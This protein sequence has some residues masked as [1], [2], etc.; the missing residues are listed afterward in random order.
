MPGIPGQVPSLVSSR[1][2]SGLFVWVVRR[3]IHQHRKNSYYEILGV[4]PNDNQGDIKKAFYRLSMELHPDKATGNEAKFREIN[5]AYEVLGNLKLRRLYD[6][7]YLPVGA[8]AFADSK[9]APAADQGPEFEEVDPHSEFAKAGQKKQWTPRGRTP[10]YDFDEWTRAHYSDAFNRSQQS[11][12]NRHQQRRRQ[13]YDDDWPHPDFTSRVR[14]AYDHQDSK[15]RQLEIMLSMIMLMIMGHLVFNSSSAGN[16]DK[17][18]P[19]PP[20]PPR[21]KE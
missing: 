13:F 9:T 5:T 15:G 16:Y 12:T 20:K 1:S 7:G 11:S 8:A 21:D 19:P 14:S 17:R 10:I 18:V 6:K 4:S 3:W 2:G